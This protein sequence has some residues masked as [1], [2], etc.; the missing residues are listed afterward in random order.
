MHQRFWGYKIE[1]KLH[2][3]VREQERL[4]IAGIQSL[5][6][7]AP[8]EPKTSRPLSERVL[9]IYCLLFTT[10]AVGKGTQ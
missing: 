2:V 1:A 8:Q 3:G 6:I 7:L 4:N 9:P 5:E 10:V